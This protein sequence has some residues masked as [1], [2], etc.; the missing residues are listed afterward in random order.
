MSSRFLGIDWSFRG[1]TVEKVDKSRKSS[2][3]DDASSGV[4]AYSGETVTDINAMEITAFSS[5]VNA[6]ATSFAQLPIHVYKTRA[7]RRERDRNAPLQEILGSTVNEDLLT[8]YDWKYGLIHSYY[9]KGRGYTAIL[10]N[11]KGEAV[12]LE[13]LNFNWTQRKRKEGRWVY[14]YRVPGEELEVFEARDV[15]DLARLPDH[16]CPSG[17]GASPAKLH[18][19]TIGLFIAAE[20]YASKILS[21]GG[22]IPQQLVS[23]FD[24]TSDKAPSAAVM[25]ELRDVA[26]T[27]LQQAARTD[28]KFFANAPGY[29][30]EPIGVNP[31]DLQLLEL[32]RALILDIARVFNLPPMFLQD[33]STGTFTNTEQQASVLVKHTLMPIIVQFQAQLNSKLAGKNQDVEVNVDAFL[34]GDYAV[35]MEG[36]AKSIQNAIRTPNEVRALEGLAPDPDGDSLFIQGATVP[37]TGLGSGWDAGRD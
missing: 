32:K 10:R 24:P 1:Q 19:H 6:L 25:K 26:I 12:S 29:R 9:A 21:D 36:H 37:L 16:N 14:E 35:R 33:L 30:L 27:A 28:T 20:K 31:G 5:A 15:I 2:I 18:R 4:I 34:R 13:P 11:G 7:G 22:I 3:W 23:T 8:A 17:V